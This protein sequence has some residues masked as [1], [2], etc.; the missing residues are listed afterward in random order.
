MER[1]NLNCQ[2]QTLHINATHSGRHKLLCLTDWTVS[3]CNGRPSC[4]PCIAITR[5]LVGE[6]PIF[7]ADWSIPPPL[8]IPTF[9][10]FVPW[11]VPYKMAKRCKTE[12]AT[13]HKQKNAQPT[14]VEKTEVAPLHANCCGAG[15]PVSILMSMSQTCLFLRPAQDAHHLSLGHQPHKVG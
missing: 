3:S 6:R 5:E 11:S 1:T 14:K 4:D 12:S 7:P 15:R 2:P 9:T 10:K 13:K 8:Q